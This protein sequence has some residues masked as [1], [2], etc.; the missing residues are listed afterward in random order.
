MRW[1]DLKLGMK[2]A[3]GFGSVTFIL[4]GIVIG[5]TWGFELVKM[6]GMQVIT[7]NR[8]R[9]SL[10]ER[11]VDHLN[12]AKNLSNFLFDDEQTE[13]NIELDHTK[14]KFGKW[15][16]NHNEK[17]H[18]ETAEEAIAIVPELKDALEDIKDPHQKLHESAAKIQVLYTTIDSKL[19][20]FLAKKEADHLAWAGHVQQA[21]LLKNKDLNV[22]FDPHLC[23]FGKFLYGVKGQE[24]KKMDQVFAKALADIEKPHTVLHTSGQEIQ[25]ALE[26]SEYDMAGKIYANQLSPALTEVR[27]VLD[28]LQSH[29]LEL[30][31]SKEAAIA[32]YTK[33]TDPNLRE[34][35]KLLGEMS[36]TVKDNILTEDQMMNHAKQIQ[37]AAGFAGLL[38]VILGILLAWVITYSIAKPIRMGVEFAEKVAA[39]DLTQKLDVEQKDEVGQLA[40]ALQKMIAKLSEIVTDVKQASMNVSSGSSE[41]SSS[42]ETMSE[43]ASEQ[44]ASAEEVSSAMQEIGDRIRRNTEHAMTTEGISLQVSKEMKVG[45][46]AVGQTVRAMKDIADKISIIEEISRQ[47][48][49][50]A[51]NAAIEA[52]RAGEHG[53]GF[54]VVASEVRKLAERSQIAANEI[55]Q[56]SVS[57]VDTAEDAGQKLDALVPEI[58]KTVDL[59]QE[60]AAASKE[61]SNGVDQV[62][63]AIEQ[64]NDVVQQNAAAAEEMASTSE[65]LSA[66]AV[67]LNDL[68]T[69][70]NVN[71]GPARLQGPKSSSALDYDYS[72]EDA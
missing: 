3:I 16:Y 28:K 58:Q 14:C 29:A 49:L 46:E 23:S 64:L 7:G 9:G 59:I 8:I 2:L 38:A 39:G 1:K 51:L 22:E 69:Y 17:G 36:D 19:P 67:Q 63:T 41:L 65:E 70:F 12:W 32:V 72:E 10:L 24:L 53:K 52:A 15:L 61:Q 35:Q 55:S 71:D 31:A 33:Q 60:I 11:E 68:M 34:V 21:I 37:Y 62:S 42:S 47:T 44:A 26:N 13:L 56:L 5:V 50:L 25:K 45:N 6:D 54:A 20:A 57:S 27:E 43:G 66:Q 40:L 4:A 18:N 30:I 48:N